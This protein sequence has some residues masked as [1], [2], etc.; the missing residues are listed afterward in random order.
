MNRS[1]QYDQHDPYEAPV[2]MLAVDAQLSDR[3]SFIRRVYTHVFGALALMVGIEFLL[4]KTGLAFTLFQMIGQ[5][6]ILAIFAFMAITWVAERMAFSQASTAVQYAGLG[7]FVAVQSVLAAPIIAIAAAKNPDLIGQAAFLT[8]AITGGLTL[9]V[10]LSNVDFSFLR[11]ILFLGAIAALV[12]SIAAAIWGFH[13]GIVFSGAIV[14]LMC[15]YILYETSLIMRHLPTTAH[16]AGALM[17]FGSISV[18]FRQI[19][20]I[21]VRMNED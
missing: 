17:I 3:L 1:L 6:W 5:A 14:V 4:F 18:L 2:S 9:V 19:L 12:I 21:L 8:L 15:G 16:V 11:N 13:L 7:M 20:I 10:V